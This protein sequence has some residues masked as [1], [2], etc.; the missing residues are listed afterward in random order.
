MERLPPALRLVVATRVDPP[1]PLGRLRARG[2]LAELR[3]ER[4]SLQRGGDDGVPDR[5]PRARPV[6][7]RC[8][9]AAART[10]GWPAAL[11]L[12]ALSLR[13]RADASTLIDE[14]AGDDR[15]LVDYLTGELLA[16]QRPELYSFLLRTSILNRLC[17]SLCDAVTERDDS[18][19][20]WPSSSARTCCSSR[21]TRSASGTATTTSSA[22]SSGTNSPGADAGR[23]CPNLHR[24]AY[25][26]YR[27]AGLIVDAAGHAITA[28]DF[29]AA[30]ELV[31]R[32][33]AF[34]VDQG[35]I[36][37]VMRWL[38]AIARGR[39]GSGT[40]C[41]ASPPRW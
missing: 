8:Q 18:A 14:F 33:Y 20:F 3:A 5:G 39:G 30:G 13:G 7:R 36:A 1:L 19:R 15:Y 34:F 25:A 21:S 17:A 9:P 29:D 32:H 26:W 2:E 27:D 4:S 10:E 22:I 28:G 11:Y 31:A 12:A 16:R 35:Q 41:S 6:R 23:S 40:G 37:T 38:D 24:R